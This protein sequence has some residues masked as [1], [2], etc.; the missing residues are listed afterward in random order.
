V[1]RVAE[2][3]ALMGANELEGWLLL[4]GAVPDG[5]DCSEV[6][7]LRGFCFAG[8]MMMMMK[9]EVGCGNGRALNEIKQG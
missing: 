3:V 6:L 4:D 8:M 1:D 5:E 7:C 2:L 9:T